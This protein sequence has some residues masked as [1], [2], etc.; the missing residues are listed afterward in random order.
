VISEVR[1]IALINEQTDSSD[2]P[3]GDIIIK[4]DFTYFEV[5]DEFAE[6]L[7][8][9]F[10]GLEYHGETVLSKAE[11]KPEPSKRS[12]NRYRKEGSRGGSGRNGRGGSGGGRGRSK[13]GSSRGRSD[14][15]ERNE[16]NSSRGGG[17]SG[18]RKKR[19]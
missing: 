7:E 6:R 10:N 17:K 14:R 16:R 9:A 11:S 13:R 12:N 15:A 8:Q 18:R 2:I 1:L 5:G 4:P 19:R 3:I